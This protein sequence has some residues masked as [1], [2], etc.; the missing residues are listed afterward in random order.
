MTSMRVSMSLAL[1]LTVGPFLGSFAHAVEKEVKIGDPVANFT[2]KDIHLLPRTLDEFPKPR[3]FVLVFT[4]TSCPLV[5]QYFPTLK[6]LYK[7]YKDKDVQFLAV[8]VGADDSIL[9]MAA[10]AVRYDVEF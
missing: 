3:A 6:S 8:N 4:N 10:Q 2:V 5:Q 7:D 1:A 9:T